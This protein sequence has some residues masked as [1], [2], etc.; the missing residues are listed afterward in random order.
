MR[1]D[2]TNGAHNKGFAELSRG[3]GPSD[4]LSIVNNFGRRCLGVFQSS[5]FKEQSME[6]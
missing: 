2:C 4:A 5:V 3:L 1:V 6:A